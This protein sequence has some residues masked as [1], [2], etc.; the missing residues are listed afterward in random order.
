MSLLRA[1]IKSRFS[2]QAIRPSHALPFFLRESPKRFSTETETPACADASSID[3]FLRTPNG[4]VYGRL[5]GVTIRKQTLKSDIINLLESVDL[6][7]DDV[8]VNYTRNFMPVGILLQLRSSTDFDHAFKA[9]AKKGRMYRLDKVNR[10]DWD[11]VMPYNG[12]T[13]L[14]EG[15]PQN[16]QPDDVERF[17]SGCEFDASSIQMFVRPANPELIRM[18]T[19]RFPSQTQAMNAYLRKNRG[20]CLN[21]QIS[22]RVLQ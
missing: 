13:V 14:L 15:I 11:I 18:A 7:P 10:S 20:F 2:L 4:G 1:A 3:P 8:K 21:N 5:S 16:A 17:L 19:V 9:I 6:T 22:M 12:K